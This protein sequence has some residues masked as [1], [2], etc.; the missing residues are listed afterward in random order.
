VW[1]TTTR[2]CASTPRHSASSWRPSGRSST[3][4]PSCAW[5]TCAWRLHARD[6]RRRP[7]RCRAGHVRRLRPPGPR[8]HPSLPARGDSRR[9]PG[10][11][12]PPRCR[13]FAEPFEVEPIGQRL[14]L[15]EDNSCNL[16]ELARPST[17]ATRG[18]NHRRGPARGSAPPAETCGR[19][20]FEGLPERSN[21]S[22]SLTL[23]AA[24]RAKPGHE[25][26][27]R[28][29]LNAMVEPSEAEPGCLGYRPLV[30]PNAPGAMV[31]VEEWID[32]A[33]LEFHFT[34]PISSA[35]PPSSRR[36]SPS[37]S[38][39]GCSPPL[40]GRSPKR[41]DRRGQRAVGRPT[42]GRPLGSDPLPL[43]ADVQDAPSRG[44]PCPSR[45]FCFA[46]ARE[47][48][49]G[50]AREDRNGRI[51]SVRGAVTWTFLPAA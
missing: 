13:I 14:A 25:D 22:D 43:W 42:G 19:K 5:P 16:I 26:R 23:I 49:V 1:P 24:F 37:P 51:G 9:R 29:E 2:P 15:I 33:A 40:P 3:R 28:E 47:R 32:R 21:M 44:S 36:S 11:A 12:T 46:R 39:F 10:R 41:P 34:T 50:R 8:L 30:D 18:A 48:L 7:G 31:I 27:L 35:L 4:S 17:P 38:R 45:L 6:H 20:P